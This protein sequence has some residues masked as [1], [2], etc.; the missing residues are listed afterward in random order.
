MASVGIRAYQGET[1]IHRHDHHQ[2]VLPRR[3]H[4]A[5]E[6]AGREGVVSIGTGA[7]I[8]ADASHTFVAS[9]SDAFIV[10]DVPHTWHAANLA[11]PAEAAG[12][13]FPI[14]PAVQAL[15][16]HFTAARARRLRRAMT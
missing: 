5:I 10:A 7:F 9:A 15:L 4:M 16:D 13:F 8:P 14:S 6:I 2:I 12:A 3:G 11:C 1:S